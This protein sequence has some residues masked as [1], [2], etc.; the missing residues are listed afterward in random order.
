MAD[1]DLILRIE[2]VHAFCGN[3]HALKGVSL[4]VRRNAVVALLGANGAGKT[5]MLRVISALL[6][7]ARGKVWFEHKPLLRTAPERVVGRGI[8]HVPEG[9]Q[10]FGDLTVMENLRIG[11]FLRNDRKSIQSD[12]ERVLEL[13]PRL[14][15]RGRQAAQTLSGGEQQMLSIARALMARPKLLLLDEPSLGLAPIIVDQI[16]D[17]I[18]AINHTGTTILLVEQNSEIALSISNYAYV[19]ETGRVALEGQSAALLDNAQIKSS[20]FGSG[21]IDREISSR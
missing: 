19:L 9:R 16:V 15:E 2:D 7:A 21:G 12:T 17:T 6:P 20:Y 14:R 11:A 10:I 18:K 3:I 1:A 13:F 8:S 4:A 5:T